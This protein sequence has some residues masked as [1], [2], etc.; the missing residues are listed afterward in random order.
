MREVNLRRLWTL[1]LMAGAVL[2]IACGTAPA[3]DG[4]RPA[5]TETAAVATPEPTPESTPA[6]ALPAVSTPAPKAT[7]EPAP[8][9]KAAA[10]P[11]PAPKPVPKPRTFTLQAGTV[12]TIHLEDGLSSE[13]AV[14]GQAVEGVVASAAKQ[15]GA[16]IIPTGARVEGSVVEVKSAKRFGGQATLVV[17]FDRV[18][19]PT[20]RSVPVEGEIVALAKK[21][22]G[23]DA[24]KIGGGAA[25]GALLGRLLGKD[26]KSTALG[27][28]VGAGVG[29]AVASRKG[30][31]A[32]FDAGFETTVTTL[33][34]TSITRT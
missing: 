5:V 7:P 32:V 9:R 14:P 4:S 27:A 12:L 17:R 1:T 29:T 3:P 21:E 34:S 2:T 30:Q 19:L 31:E 6:T 22:A 18:H 26:K 8:A 28:A 10:A 23:K 33:S 11:K 20:G 13:S 16:T 25:G 24:A 15:G